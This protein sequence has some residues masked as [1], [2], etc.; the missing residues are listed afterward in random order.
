MLI[1]NQQGLSPGHGIVQLQ[2]R[3]KAASKAHYTVAPDKK[4]ASVKEHY[5]IN[6]DYYKNFQNM[7]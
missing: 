6:P 5:S 7:L 4:T 1:Q 3:K 2:K